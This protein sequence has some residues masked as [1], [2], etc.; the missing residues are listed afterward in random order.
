[1]GSYAKPISD[2]TGV[3]DPKILELIE[4]EMRSVN[5]HST[6]DWIPKQQF[7]AGAKQA[8]GLIRLQQRPPLP[9]GLALDS[10]VEDS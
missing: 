3:D 5:F 6:L 9:A 7:V 4:E 1:M 8:Y 10:L 2:A